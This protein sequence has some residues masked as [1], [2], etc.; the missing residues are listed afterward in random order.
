MAFSFIYKYTLK[1][2]RDWIDIVKPTRIKT[3]PVV[4]SQSEVARIIASARVPSYAAYIYATYSMGL[5]LSES[6]NITVGDIDSDRMRIHIRQSKYKK[7]RYVAMPTSTLTVLRRYWVQHRNPKLI[8]PSGRTPEERKSAN[9]PLAKHTIHK[10]FKAIVASC[11]IHKH[12]SIHTLRHSYATHL[13]ES[14]MHLRS[15]QAALGHSCPKTTTRYTQ[16]T[17]ALYQDS[18]E[19]INQV[20]TSVYSQVKSE[21]NK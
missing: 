2:E 16:L 12:V 15:I 1:K 13:M 7:D 9:T 8:F 21:V 18:E 5:R 11:N 3:L 10:A 4:L 20:M 6:R 17:K 14:G 19:L